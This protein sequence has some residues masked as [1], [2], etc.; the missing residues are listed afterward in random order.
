MRRFD[1]FGRLFT[2]VALCAAIFF[3]SLSLAQ[4][5]TCPAGS[6]P[7]CF[8]NAAGNKICTGKCLTCSE[9][10]Q[11]C[12]GFNK[13]TSPRNKTFCE[14]TSGCVWSTVRYNDCSQ[15]SYCIPDN[16]VCPDL[17]ANSGLCCRKGY[18]MEIGV[19]PNGGL[20]YTCVLKN[21]QSGVDLCSRP[22]ECNPPPKKAQCEDGLDNDNDNKIDF[23][24]DHGCSD[25]NDNDEADSPPP[26]DKIGCCSNEK[27]FL[28]KPPSKRTYCQLPSGKIQNPINLKFCPREGGGSGKACCDESLPALSKCATKGNLNVRAGTLEELRS[29]VRIVNYNGQCLCWPRNLT[30]SD[31]LDNFNYFKMSAPKAEFCAVVGPSPEPPIR[32][33]IPFWKDWFEELLMGNFITRY[34]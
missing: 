20:E 16:N 9:L 30:W 14:R 1:V 23:P 11:R 28:T 22:G 10:N 34:R 24:D 8:Y 2:I 17:Y 21:Y 6:V 15:K 25:N 13:F 32:K 29:L 19:G 3:I 27:I 26:S 18:E 5:Q 12:Q 33:I 31:V 7:D 4:A